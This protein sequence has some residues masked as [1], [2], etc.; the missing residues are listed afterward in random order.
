MKTHV[1]AKD[2]ITEEMAPGV[3][4]QIVGYDSNIMMVKVFFEKKRSNSFKRS[5]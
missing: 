4:R 3:K 2:I 1:K 5:S